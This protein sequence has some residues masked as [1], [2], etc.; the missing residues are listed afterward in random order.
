VPVHGEFV[1]YWDL[2]G[3]LPKHKRHD[4]DYTAGALVCR[5]ADGR[6]CVADIARF[7]KSVAERNAELRRIAEADLRTYRGRLTW[8]IE[9]EAGIAGEERT[10]ELVRELQAMGLAVHTE[11]PTGS[12]VIRAEPLAAKAEAGNIV[13]GP[14]EWRDAF[15]TEAAD[16][17]NGKHDD[18]I[19]AVVGAT[20]KLAVPASAWGSSTFSSGYATTSR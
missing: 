12:K 4:P 9:T 18:Q 6:F 19:D 17:P 13:L 10:D 16:F 8:W 2:A 7:R 3:T 1:R 20:A 5:R 14:G 11:R 15:R